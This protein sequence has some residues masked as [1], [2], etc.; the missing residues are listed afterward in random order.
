PATRT[1]NVTAAPA[2]AAVRMHGQ[3]PS[4]NASPVTRGRWLA[5]PVPVVQGARPGVAAERD[6]RAPRQG[7]GAAVADRAAGEQAAQGVDH[8][9]EWLIFREPAHAS[10]HRLRRDERAADERQDDDEQRQAVGAG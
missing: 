10:W 4:T 3:Y 2:N 5:W 6:G 7:Q 1:S 9:G 8:R